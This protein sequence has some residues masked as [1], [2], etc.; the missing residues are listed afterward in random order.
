M[1][2][3]R[4]EYYHKQRPPQQRDDE[5]MDK[6]HDRMDKWMQHGEEIYGQAEAIVGKQ[7]HGPT[8]MVKLKFD[9]PTTR[10]SNPDDNDQQP[11]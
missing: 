7:R 8:G 3:Y 2:V 6:F 10:F 4:E 5:P 11:A 1:F 9:G